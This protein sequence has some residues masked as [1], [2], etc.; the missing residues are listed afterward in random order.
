MTK[1]Q[2]TVD[3]ADTNSSNTVSILVAT[4]N[5]LGYLEK[6]PVRGEDSF[7]TFEEILRLAQQHEVDMILLGGDLFHDN[8]PSRSCIHKTMS[9]LR[10]YCMGD[11]PCALDFQSDPTVNFPDQF[12]TVNYQDPNYNISMPVFSIHGNHDDPSGDGNLCALDLLSVSGLCNYFGR[13]RQIDDISISPLLLRKG[14]TRLA[15]YGLVRVLRPR[16]DTDEWFNLMVIHQ[17]RVAHGPSNYIP[18]AFLDDLFHLV[19]WGHEHE[20]L[21]DPDFNEIQKFY[22]SQPGSSVATSLSEGESKRKFVGL[23]KIKGT[24]FKMQK[25]PLQTVRP[26]IIK[27]VILSNVG[28]LRPSDEKGVMNYLTKTV[29]KM[30]DTAHT[31]W[32]DNRSQ[33]SSNELTDNECPRPLIRL[34][35]DYSEGYTAFHPQRFGQQFVDRVANPKDILQFHRRRTIRADAQERRTMSESRRVQLESIMPEKLENFRVEDLVEEMLNDTLLS[36]FPENAF[37]GAVR[38]FVE[39]DDRDAIKEFIEEM[40]NAAQ[41]SLASL[42]VMSETDL[43]SKAEEEKK[44]QSLKYEHQ[45]P[46]RQSAVTTTVETIDVVTS[47]S[48]DPIP[49]IESPTNEVHL[50]NDNDDNDDMLDEKKAIW[51]SDDDDDEN[52]KEET[53]R[54]TTTNS[55][56]KRSGESSVTIDQMRYSKKTRRTSDSMESEISVISTRSRS[57]RLSNNS[58][59][60]GSPPSSLQKPR[61]TRSNASLRRQSDDDDDDGE[62]GSFMRFSRSTH[63]SNSRK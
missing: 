11:R 42:S 43:V 14:T 63:S 30:I 3:P 19:V 26:F 51:L 55:R 31:E 44:M 5:H 32:K 15:L 56:N 36:V 54:N 41:T 47:T 23:L 28:G 9:L 20:C 34:R 52:Y 62:E 6:D 61:K 12:G 57:D 27:D 17:N 22:V 59:S 60:M 49:K 24:R 18:E 10:Q 53:K 39:K 29:N 13:A 33:H 45:H 25:L 16:E 7:R 35:V 1:P 38:Q 37:G 40:L 50:L 58:N 4:D 8:K 2:D 48:T 21:I 46:S